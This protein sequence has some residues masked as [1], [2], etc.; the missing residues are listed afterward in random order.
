MIEP[1]LHTGLLVLVAELTDAAES[2]GRLSGPPSGCLRQRW[3][4]A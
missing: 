3:P 2:R 4:R 1:Q